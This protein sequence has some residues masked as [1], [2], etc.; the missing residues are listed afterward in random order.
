MPSEAVPPPPPPPSTTPEGAQSNPVPPEPRVETTQ[1]ATEPEPARSPTGAG[2]D[3]RGRVRPTR[4]S[5]LWIGLITAAIFG[6]LLI[7][8]IA[9]NSRSVPLHFFGWR[10]QF[11]LALT[12]LVSAAI[13]LLLVAIPGTIRILQLRSALRKNAA[14]RL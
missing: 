14:N 11:S 10:G 3:S 12:I 2:L 6:I 4:I 5:G 1:P 8:F 13:G 7:V 9:Q